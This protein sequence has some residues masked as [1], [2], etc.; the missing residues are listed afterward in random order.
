MF[1]ITTILTTHT[2]SRRTYPSVSVVSSLG[3]KPISR[4]ITSYN[5]ISHTTPVYFGMVSY[6]INYRSL[7]SASRPQVLLFA[8]PLIK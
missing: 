2:Q 1:Y 3:L 7:M 8:N 4:E 5:Y 6:V